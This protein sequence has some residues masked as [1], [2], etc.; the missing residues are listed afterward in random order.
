MLHQPSR[1]IYVKLAGPLLVPPGLLWLAR[2]QNAVLLACCVI[3][4]LG[5]VR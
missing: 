4:M 1:T 3:A 5:S 2:R